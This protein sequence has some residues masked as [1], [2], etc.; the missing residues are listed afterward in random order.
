MEQNVEDFL[1][2]MKRTGEHLESYRSKTT[3]G[4]TDEQLAALEVPATLILHHG[5]ESDDLH[6]ITN[7][8]A[9]TTL[10]Q[11]STFKFAAT[12]ETVLDVLLP[13]V[14]KYTPVMETAQ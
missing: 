9:A 13:F 10:L 2:A 7:S 6:P 5:S 1:V 12:L 14:K 8:R 4:M 11:N 3:L